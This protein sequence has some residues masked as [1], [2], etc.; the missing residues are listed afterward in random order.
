MSNKHF[1]LKTLGVIGFIVLTGI[2]ILSVLQTQAAIPTENR[3]SIQETTQN[4]VTISLKNLDLE[5]A[6]PV[7]EICI[8]LPTT[9]DWLPYLSLRT[10]AVEM[11]VEEV[12]LQSAKDP[13]TYSSTSRCYRVTFNGR[14]KDING[15]VTVVVTKIQTTLPEVVSDELCDS[16]RAK[17]S[18][19]S[20]NVDFSCIMSSN[21]GSIQIVGKP[22]NMTDQEAFG[23]V[24]SALVSTVD[25]PWA[26]TVKP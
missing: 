7:A 10:S 12:A 21:G 13:A 17:L 23:L 1:R 14:S 26:F 25:G 15:E 11:P 6:K 4:G 20:P 8:D 18:V 22:A 16:G 2:L 9:E 5:L 3:K 24:Y 19:T